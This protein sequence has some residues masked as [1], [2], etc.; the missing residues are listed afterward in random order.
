MR[1]HLCTCTFEYKEMDARAC[2]VLEFFPPK[3]F[4]M[5]SS[6]TRYGLALGDCVPLTEVW[7]SALTRWPDK[8]KKKNTFLIYNGIVLLSDVQPSSANVKVAAHTITTPC[9]TLFRMSHFLLIKFTLCD[10]YLSLP[11]FNTGE[12]L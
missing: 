4:K 9:S 10:A 1:T 5:F 8:Y 6:I 7:G 2:A 12:F 3:A 11:F